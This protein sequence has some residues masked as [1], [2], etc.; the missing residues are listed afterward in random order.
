MRAEGA[1]RHMAHYNLETAPALA[2][3]AALDEVGQLARSNEL[4]QPADETGTA[5]SEAP[6]GGALLAT[7]NG[8]L[9]ILFALL[10]LINLTVILGNILVILAVYFTAKLKS[11]TNIF[12]VS[13]ATADLMLGIFVLPYALIFEVSKLL[14]SAPVVSLCSISTDLITGQVRRFP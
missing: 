9:L 14:L 10:I 1:P 5:I 8:H 4:Q 6:N 11:V 13:L 12:I 3:P 7:S 2:P